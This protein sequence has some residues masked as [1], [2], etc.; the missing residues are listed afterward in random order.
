MKGWV[1]NS[2]NNTLMTSWYLR[3]AGSNWGVLRWCHQFT[4]T[5]VFRKEK[6]CIITFVKVQA[7]GYKH[8]ILNAGN[9]CQ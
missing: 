4:E 6:T 2:L 7:P 5:D 1:K 9:S 8:K 3:S